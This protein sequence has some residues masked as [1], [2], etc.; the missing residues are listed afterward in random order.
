MNKW[1]MRLLLLPIIGL[2]IIGC[3]MR[4]N[5]EG[6]Q[7]VE[8][9]MKREVRHTASFA[10]SMHLYSMVEFNYLI[11]F[12]EGGVEFIFAHNED[13]ARELLPDGF[14]RRMAWNDPDFP[15]DVI[16][17]WPDSIPRLQGRVNGINWFVLEEGIDLAEFSLQYPIT[18]ED[19]IDEWEKVKRL[20]E[21]FDSRIRS[22]IRNEAD[23]SGADAFVQMIEAFYVVGDMEVLDQAINR[24]LKLELGW[25]GSRE[26]LIT[27]GCV[28]EYHAVLD[29]LENGEITL[30]EVLEMIEE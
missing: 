30:E 9:Q 8:E 21:S 6:D 26:L 20:W 19:V 18:I 4:K 22:S 27:L 5:Q 12:P 23:R 13:E 11:W 29:R 2:I 7:E 15:P 1:L 28:E 17:V 3:G 25:R 24:G 14:Q 16:V 10:H